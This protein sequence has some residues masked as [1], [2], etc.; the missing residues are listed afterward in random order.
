MARRWAIPILAVTV[1]PNKEPVYGFRLNGLKS[2]SRDQFIATFESV[3]RDAERRRARGAEGKTTPSS[4]ADELAKFAK[5]RDDG[6]ISN[7]EFEAKKA[8]LLN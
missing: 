6:V 4:A 3:V 5:L 2:D 1:E 7:E 8:Q